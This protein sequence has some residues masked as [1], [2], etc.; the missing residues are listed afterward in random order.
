MKEVDFLFVY[1]VKNREYDNLCLLSCELRRRGYTVGYQSFWYCT[2]HLNYPHYQ[3]KVAAVATCYKD[4]VYRTFTSFAGQFEKVVN[5]Q[6]EQIPPNG[7]LEKESAQEW[8]EAE[9]N[10]SGVL[11]HNVRYISWGEKNRARLEEIVGVEPKNICVAGYVTLDF[12]R[13]QFETLF[14]PR[15][16]L[17]AKYHIDPEKRTALI[18]SSFVFANLPKLNSVSPLMGGEGIDDLKRASAESQKSLMEWVRAAL[19]EQGKESVQIIYRPHPSELENPLL[20]KMARE[21]PG[22]F[23]VADETIRHWLKACDVVY[24]WNSTTAVEA[25]YSG[26]PTYLIRPVPLPHDCQMPVFNQSRGIQT[27]EE[28]LET[29]YGKDDKET[30]QKYGL[31]GGTLSAYYDVA[32]RPSYMRVC[33][34]L[35]AVYQDQTFSSPV[36]NTA[37][38]LVYYKGMLRRV[39]RA[40]HTHIY[41]N[42]ILNPL[43]YWLRFRLYGAVRYK[44]PRQL[45]LRLRL[46]KCVLQ[47][48]VEG[49][50]AS[51]ERRQELEQKKLMILQKIEEARGEK[52]ELNA[53]RRQEA[54]AIRAQTSSLK[55]ELQRYKSDEDYKIKYEHDRQKA[56]QHYISEREFTEGIKRID[57]LL[58][59][60]EKIER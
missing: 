37:R 13:P 1:D 42:H 38:D 60:I 6:W 20:G 19:A 27:Y 21:L 11:Q 48:T 46:L 7:I 50:G 47:L 35:E 26:T 12:Y 16:K 32:E 18:V 2:T 59:D 41:K 3:P 40:L 57:A 34:F 5:L 36:W 30:Q 33:D 28:F 14:I 53:L 49:K 39:R 17:F 24:N 15:K 54:Q 9:W 22:F 44:M 23:L 51:G 43:T 29:L 55:K 25:Y 8:A 10:S 58:C 4:A 31:D 45:R 56:K 52:T